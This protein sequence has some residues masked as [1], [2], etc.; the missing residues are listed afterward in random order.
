M[1]FIMQRVRCTR[2]AIL[3]ITFFA[4]LY[5][6][7]IY[8]INRVLTENIFVTLLLCFVSLFSFS[9]NYSGRKKYIH[10]G[11]YALS[12][13]F[14]GMATYIRGLAFPFLLLGL[15]IIICYELKDKWKSLLTFGISFIATQF[16]WWIRNIVQFHKFIL[17][18]EAGEGPK[19]WGVM[20]Y[21]LDMASSEN[22]SFSELLKLNTSINL[23]V[24]LKWRVFGCINYLW[25][26]VWDEGM[27]HETLRC[28]LWIHIII[29]LAALVLPVLFRYCNQDVLLISSFPI[30]FTAMNMLYHGLNRYIWPAL[31]FCLISLGMILSLSSHK[32]KLALN[33]NL[34]C[35]CFYIISII[36]SILL[37]ISIILFS[38]RIKSEM[39]EWRLSKYLNTNIEKVEQGEI[40]LEKSYTENDVIIENSIK[41]NSIWCNNNMGPSII[42]LDCS[43]I[44]TEQNN[45]VTKIELNLSGGYLWDFQVIYWTD[46]K[47][48]NISENRCYS[49]PI[50]VFQDQ[51]IIYIDDDVD[52]LE[53]VPIRF[54]GG[55]FKYDSIK[56]SKIKSI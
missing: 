53:I 24:F 46:R 44:M 3:I 23:P 2:K 15:F 54:R 32:A 6:G 37:F 21:Y 51:Q 47:M 38:G 18:S 19:I 50:N 17:L 45:V 7:F 34:I 5:P 55:K 35:R 41:M 13:I 36:F 42:K 4:A 10:R 29:V 49:Y 48:Q 26:D 40:I 1:V 52:F 22:Y 12:A 33:N 43:D 30:A 56:V 31:P 11:G 14:L 9:I 16:P 25:N 8:N 20:P 28:L 27:S 39:S